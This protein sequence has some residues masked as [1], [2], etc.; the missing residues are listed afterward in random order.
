M[1]NRCP[2]R[3]KAG[4]GFLRKILLALAAADDPADP[5]GERVKRLAESVWLFRATFWP[6]Q[7]I[8]L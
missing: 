8:D 2:F 5:G 7:R 6:S 3:I 4:A 1:E